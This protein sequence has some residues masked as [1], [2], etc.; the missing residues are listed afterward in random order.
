VV[1][2]LGP[3]VMHYTQ[4]DIEKRDDWDNTKMQLMFTGVTR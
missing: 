1:I 4:F 3:C 2:A